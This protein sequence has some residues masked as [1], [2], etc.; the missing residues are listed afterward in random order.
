M[1]GENIEIIENMKT[2]DL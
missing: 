1:I 2:N